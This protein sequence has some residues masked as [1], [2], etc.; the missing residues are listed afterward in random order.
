[1]WQKITSDTS[2]ATTMSMFD[3]DQNGEVELVYRDETLLRIIDKNGNN[4]TTAPCISATHT[5]Y[6]IIVDIDR[7]GHADIIVSGGIPGYTGTRLARFSS[8]TANQWAYCR[9]VW[10]QHGYNATNI[11]EDLSIPQYPLNPATAFPGADGIVGTADDIRP[12]NNFLQQQTRLGGNGKT[13]WLAPDATPIYFNS[14]SVYVDSIVHVTLDIANIGDAVIG[15]KIYVSLYKGSTAIPAFKTDSFDIVIEPDSSAIVSMSYTDVSALN[16]PYVVVARVNDKDPK[17]AYWPE[18]DSLNNVI[19]LGLMTKAA[20]RE[21]N[22]PYEFAHTGRNANPVSVLYSEKIEYTLRVTNP[23]T[24]NDQPIIIRDTLPAYLDTVS[25]SSPVPSK[26]VIGNPQRHIL[27]WNFTDVPSQAIREVS[28]VTTPVFG[29]SASQPLFPNQAWMTTSEFGNSKVTPTNRTYHQGAGIALV[30]F[31][32]SL[33]GSIFGGSAQ[34]VD[35]RTTAARGVIVVPD[36]G[37]VFV[38]WMHNAYTSLRGDYIPA[39]YGIMQYEDLI[40]HGD[41]EL[42]AVFEPIDILSIYSVLEE[43]IQ[44]LEDNIW[45]SQNTLYIR[46]QKSGNIVRIYTVSGALYDQRTIL[47]EGTTSIKLPSGIYVVTL[48]NGIGYKVRIE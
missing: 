41:V 5:E 12:Y 37:Y 38:G 32:A 20:I 48:N 44:P 22:T 36:S 9:S 3:F 4:L 15:P 42:H 1:M 17:F 43:T 19:N 40:I 29:V 10:N 11:N 21:P 26:A 27:T 34:T 13:S 8:K 25:F 45:A 23:A 14:S 6:P 35:F 30:T 31:S 18:C 47:V 46:T 7:D 28:Y 33:G 2:G 24:T 39:A 16:N